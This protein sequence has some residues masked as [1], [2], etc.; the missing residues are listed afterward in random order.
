[1]SP[2]MW[3][4]VNLTAVSCPAHSTIQSVIRNFR[5]ISSFSTDSC[6]SL[7]PVSNESFGTKPLK[8][9]KG[10]ALNDL[11]KQVATFRELKLSFSRD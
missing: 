8:I 1:M 6:Y 2:G 10:Y 7:L 3:L 5:T 11:G 4:T 9:E